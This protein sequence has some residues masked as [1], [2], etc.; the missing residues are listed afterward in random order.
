MTELTDK[1]KLIELKKLSADLDPIINVG[2]SGITESLIEELKKQIKE[3]KLVKVRILKNAEESDDIKEA[4][5]LL[6]E[7]TDSVIVDI[8]GRTVSFYRK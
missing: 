4:A 2:K 1:K 8:R 5:A 6:A 7:R 3:K